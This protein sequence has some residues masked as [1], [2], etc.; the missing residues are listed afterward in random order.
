MIAQNQI[1]LAEELADVSGEIIRQ[2]FRQPNLSSQ[3]K[4]KEIS[5]TIVTIADQQ[6]ETAM[7]E[8]LLT[9]APQ[10]GIIRE[11]GENFPSQSGLYWVLD[12]IDGTSAFARGLP[13]FGTLIGLVDLNN[14]K[15]ILGIVNQP[16]LKERWLGVEGKPTL[17]NST[18]IVNVYATAINT[19][20][21]EACLTSTT[22]LMFNTQ[23]QQDISKKLQQ[24]CTRTCFGGDCYNYVSLASGWSAMPMIILESDMKYYDFCALIPI[25]QGTGGVITDWLGNPLNANSTEVLATSNLVLHQQALSVIS[26]LA[27]L[28]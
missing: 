10:D 19:S 28:S 5:S 27:K 16:I 26:P 17:L 15:S 11:E 7:V 8:I 1:Q 25:I 3:T 13:I 18:P 22:P 6:A 2:A 14:N 24:V 12:P 23:R 4:E 20:L 9:K 21:Q